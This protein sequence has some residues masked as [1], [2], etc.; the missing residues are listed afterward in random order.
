MT[1]KQQ[2]FNEVMDQ[3][4]I[5]DEATKGEMKEGAISVHSVNNLQAVLLSVSDGLVDP[6]PADFLK[7][8]SRIQQA[9]LLNSANNPK[10]EEV[11]LNAF[12]GKTPAE[13]VA[14]SK[15]LD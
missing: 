10:P 13:I 1:D 5:L 4:G 7:A 15:V 6:K 9:V 2:S 14:N 8:C 11:L 12:N 3:L